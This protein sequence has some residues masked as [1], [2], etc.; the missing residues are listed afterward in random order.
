MNNKKNNSSLK[1]RIATALILLPIALFSIFELP[2][3][4]FSI[5]TGI[6][7]AIG[8]WEWGPFIG[9]SKKRL[10]LSLVAIVIGL[11]A[12]LFN[13]YELYHTTDHILNSAY[14]E[15]ALIAAAS[16][17]IAALGLVLTYPRSAHG[18]KSFAWL[19]GL[20]GLVTLLPTWIAAIAIRSHGY[21][22][23]AITGAWLLLFVFALVWAADIG[24]YFA[25][26]AFGQHKLMPNVSPGKTMEGMFGGL[27]A[28][29]AVVFLV[30][31][32][33]LLSELSGIQVSLIA[34][35]VIFS[36]VLGDLLESMLKRQAGVKD[37]GTILPG[38]GGILDRI[39]SLTA[40]L[41]I[42][43]FLFFFVS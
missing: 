31:Q 10:R 38:H 40:A 3:W 17:W 30:A 5:F 26:K 4:G 37:S 13:H 12:Y 9:F 27:V 14:T 20:F 24:A 39:D 41:P 19:K 42:F 33:S 34:L 43:A 35:A 36:S 2:V 6:V 22:S 23:E 1:K 7:V 28:A 32:T 11:M 21:E 8:A 15:Y 29:F 25:G 16:W 18:W